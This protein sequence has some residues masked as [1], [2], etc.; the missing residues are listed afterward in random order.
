MKIILTLGM[1]G[2]EIQSNYK[3]VKVLEWEWWNSTVLT[4]RTRTT[5]NTVTLRVVQ[6]QGSVLV[7][8]R[9]SFQISTGTPGILHDLF[10]LYR[11]YSWANAEILRISIMPARCP[12]T[13]FPSH[14]PLNLSN[15]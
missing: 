3:A 7:F 11:Q 13:S 5:K 1:E 8:V 15:I 10:S 2:K 6:Q 14:H 12:S 9:C 4:T